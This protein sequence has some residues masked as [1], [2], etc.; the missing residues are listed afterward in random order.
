MISHRLEGRNFHGLGQGERRVSS[1]RVAPRLLG[2]RI[3]EK[4]S[5][6]CLP[7]GFIDQAPIRQ[8]LGK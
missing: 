7:R 4:P 2:I 1:C 6:R 8:S 3:F 5:P